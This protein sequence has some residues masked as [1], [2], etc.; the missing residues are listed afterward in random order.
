MIGLGACAVLV[1]AALVA[2]IFPEPV[3]LIAVGLRPLAAAMFIHAAAR[4]GGGCGCA[5]SRPYALALAGSLAALFN[6][7]GVFVETR[8]GFPL[9]R[10]HGPG[11]FAVVVTL[12]LVAWGLVVAVPLLRRPGGLPLLILV[13]LLLAMAVSS[14]LALA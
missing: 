3:G 9:F 5:V 4:V 2:P 1:V 11:E 8:W 12:V 13:P 14:V 10:P 6:P 7:S